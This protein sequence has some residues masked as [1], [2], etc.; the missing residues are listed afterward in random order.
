MSVDKA[1]VSVCARMNIH[2]CMPMVVHVYISG[3][4]L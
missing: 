4:L 2:M 1:S 3:L